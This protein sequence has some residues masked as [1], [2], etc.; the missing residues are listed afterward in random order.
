MYYDDDYRKFD[1]ESLRSDLMD[2]FGT[3]AF[4]VAPIAMCDVACVQNADDDEL[5]EIAQ[6]SGFDVRKYES[7]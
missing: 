1:M 5:I 4:S 7:N 6:E 2:Y 3:A